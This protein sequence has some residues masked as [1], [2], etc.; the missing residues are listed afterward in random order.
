MLSLGLLQSQRLQWCNVHWFLNSMVG[1]A[2]ESL[3]F[4]LVNKESVSFNKFILDKTTFIAMILHFSTHFG[5]VQWGC[6]KWGFRWDNLS[7]SCLFSLTIF[8]IC[9]ALWQSTSESHLIICCI[10][11]NTQYPSVLQKSL[12]SKR[13][14]GTPIPN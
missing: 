11:I 8:M 6:N 10:I 7:S 4:W 14:I 9:K 5:G 2:V 1:K 13:N 3:G 12:V